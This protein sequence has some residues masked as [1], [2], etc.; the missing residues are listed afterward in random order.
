VNAARHSLAALTAALAAPLAG[1]V[2]L[3]RPHWRRDLRERLGALPRR[4]P[5]GIWVHAASVGEIQAASRLV[6]RLHKGGHAVFTS[7]VTL[8]GRDVMR[9]TRPEV[10]C[11]LAPLDHPWCVEA[12]LARVQPAA[13]VFIETELWPSWIAAARR[14]D[15]PVVLISA[16]LSDRSFPRYRRLRWWIRR[17]LRRFSAIGARS[18]DDGE[19]FIALGCTPEQIVVTGDLKLETDEAP[20][21]LAVDLDAALGELPLF[22]AGS[23][24]RGE[25]EAAL[26]ALDAAERAGIE[27]ALVLAPRHLERV[28]EVE[29]RVRAAG[30]TLHRR[31]ALAG[32][33][34]APGQVLL[35]DTLGEL[36]PIYARARVAFVGGSLVPIGGH[37]LLEPI[38]AGCPVLFGPHTANVRQTVEILA[39]AEAA[40]R[41]EDAAGLARAVVA[42]L[43]DP[44]TARARGEAGR[45]ALLSHRGS[46]ARSAELIEA[47]L[48]GEPARS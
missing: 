24:H 41:I 47:A 3:L 31:T 1:A 17:T 13:L 4:P 10:P 27:T 43:A 35:L 42:L 36:S 34:L 23:T 46:A 28:A 21:S 20:R 8:S 45:L 44:A 22:V 18:F 6:D 11:H 30:R 40:R 16:R 19:R 38:W 48:A 39:Q 37:N 2:L 26:G 29:R 5:G 9:R 15:I 25:E 33:R 7:T 12:A 32:A 14:H